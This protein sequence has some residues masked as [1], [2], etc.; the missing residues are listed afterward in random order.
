MKFDNVR[1]RL[2]TCVSEGLWE[3]ALAR[4]IDVSEPHN[5]TVPDIVAYV[6]WVLERLEQASG[7]PTFGTIQYLQIQSA[8]RFFE[9]LDSPLTSSPPLDELAARAYLSNEVLRTVLG[10]PSGRFTAITQAVLGVL[11]EDS[12]R[13]VIALGRSERLKW[14]RFRKDPLDLTG[15]GARVQFDRELLHSEN[16]L[17]SLPGRAVDLDLSKLRELSRR[18]KKAAGLQ[19]GPWT[20][21]VWFGTDRVALPRS[22]GAIQEF[23]NRRDPNGLV[24]YGR[25]TVSVPRTH[26]FGSIGTAWWKRILL[27]RPEDD[28]LKMT[29][30]SLS[31]QN[32]FL[33]SLRTELA[34]SEDRQ[35]LVYLHGYRTSFEAAALRAAQIGFD[36]KVRGAVAFFSWPSLGTLLGYPA[37]VAQIEASEPA[38]AE[39]ITLAVRASGANC[40]HVLAHSMGNR[41]FA[42]AV[43]RIVPTSAPPGVRFGQ[44]ILAAPDLDEALFRDLAKVYPS[45]A[46]K[47]TMYCC[48][49]DLALKGSG[50]LQASNR[51][52]F[53]PPVTVVEG[54]DTIEVNRFDVTA[55]GHGYYAGCEALL[56][57][58]KELLDHG[59]A[60]N[61]RAGLHPASTPE[62]AQYWSLA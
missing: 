37:D 13:K 50:A 16:V 42:R 34:R 3:S 14:L 35:L 6:L 58:M 15:R 21:R 7:Q 61:D 56:R 38:I 32:D 44:I 52:G 54:I 46:S 22:P 49:K 28:H 55:L 29:R 27:G 5:P 40:V 43:Q 8:A 57:D 62:G 19:T 1:E 48:P 9:E 24:R 45:I 18:N 30:C 11:D 47:A 4:R 23:G 36:L 39:F 26:L 33:S 12:A 31:N 10:E 53:T 51:V 17:P 60:P 25:C 41:G 59:A 2:R 20:Y